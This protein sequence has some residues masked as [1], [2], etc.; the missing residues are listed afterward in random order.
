MLFEDEINEAIKDYVK[1]LKK[2]SPNKVFLAEKIDPYWNNLA[3][4]AWEDKQKNG[5]LVE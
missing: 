2:E 4:K 3:T 1:I 5:E